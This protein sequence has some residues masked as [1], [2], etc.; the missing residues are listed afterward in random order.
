[1]DCNIST[2]RA[3][4]SLK[5]EVLDVCTQAITHLSVESS[6]SGF[7]WHRLMT[8]L[9]NIHEDL[10]EWLN[11]MILTTTINIRNSEVEET[12]VRKF[13]CLLY[14]NRLNVLN[15]LQRY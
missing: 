15:Q 8:P 11:V 6:A 14:Q 10:Y 12:N 4:L 2:K 7:P 13:V 3:S 1:M 9:H 5:G